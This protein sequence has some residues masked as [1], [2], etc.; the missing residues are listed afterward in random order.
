MDKCNCL[1]GI[2]RLNKCEILGI[3]DAA[4]MLLSEGL[5]NDDLNML[6]NLLIAIGSV[7]VTFASIQEK[8][9]E[10]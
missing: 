8:K 10:K 7:I 5:D 6:G 1:K 4:S 9:D 2:S 3:T